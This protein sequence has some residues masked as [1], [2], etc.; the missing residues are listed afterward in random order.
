MIIRMETIIDLFKKDKESSI[1]EI[2][3]LQSE[4]CDAVIRI[5][6]SLLGCFILDYFNDF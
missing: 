3:K 5:K 1:L 2:R 6:V 4:M